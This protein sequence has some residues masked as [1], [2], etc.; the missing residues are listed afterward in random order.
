MSKRINDPQQLE[1][2]RAESRSK[3][4]L[5]D[6]PHEVR[7]TI[8]LGTCGIAAGARD[9]LGYLIAELGSAS[10]GRVTLRQSGCAGLC[11]QEPMITVSDASGR[12][13]RY[14]RLDLAKVKEIA[15]THLVGG[16]PVTRLLIG[17]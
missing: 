11:D 17:A 2:L 3:L 9:V 6:Q 1:A 16:Q 10:A 7:V 15:A 4:E 13:F 8:H 12:E 14:G 5:R